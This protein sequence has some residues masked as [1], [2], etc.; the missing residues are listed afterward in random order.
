MPPAGFHRP[1]AATGRTAKCNSSMRPARKYWRIVATPPPRRIPRPPAA[2]LACSR[3]REYRRTK[4]K[5]SAAAIEEVVADGW[6]RTKPECDRAAHHPTSPSSSHPATV[7]GWDRTY[8]PQNPGPSPD[9]PC[10]AMSSSTPVS[11]S[12][13]SCMYCQ[14]RVG[15]NHP[16]ARRRRYRWDSGDPGSACA[17]SH[18]SNREGID[19]KL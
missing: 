17:V 2:A 18:R 6:V 12:S 8:A 19:S 14:V 1:R 11:P 9:N 16:S 10:A 3:R 13:L 15:K 7:R 4:V 5:L